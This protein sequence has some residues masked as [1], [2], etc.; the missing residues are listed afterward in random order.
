MAHVYNTWPNDYRFSD[1]DL[2]VDR[3]GG[4]GGEGNSSNGFNSGTGRRSDRRHLR[5]VRTQRKLAVDNRGDHNSAYATSAHRYQST[6]RIWEQQ[7][8]QPTRSW[9]LSHNRSATDNSAASFDANH[10]AAERE[11]DHAY[12][13][14]ITTDQSRTSVKNRNI[15]AKYMGTIGGEWPTLQVSLVSLFFLSLSL[16]LSISLSISLS[17]TH[18]SAHLYTCAILVPIGNFPALLY[19]I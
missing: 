16:S 18:T 15:C 17:P 2:P 1:N 10:A 4:S 19:L 6:S 3:V 8:Q 5:T 13:A 9:G 12:V 11:G 14:R 7:Q